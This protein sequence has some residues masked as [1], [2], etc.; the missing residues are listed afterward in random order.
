[1]VSA[2]GQAAREANR[3]PPVF[4]DD[5]AG[6]LARRHGLSADR[7]AVAG[8]SLVLLQ[9]AVLATASPGDEVLFGW[10][11]YEAYPIIVQTARCKG[12]AIPLREHRLDLGGLE[13]HISAATRI[14]IVCSPNNPTGADVTS[15]EL[16]SFLEVSRDRCLVILDEAYREFSTASDAP[17]GLE[18]QERFDHLLVLR[19]FSKAHN[20]AGARVGWGIGHPEIISALIRVALPFT[21]SRLASAAAAASVADVSAA[22][23]ARVAQITSERERVTT[24]L[25]QLGFKIPDSQANFFWVP[26]GEGS[27]E[28]SAA[29]ARRGVS[30]RCFSRRRGACHYRHSC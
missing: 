23:A 5:L 14:A 29:C 20:L 12:V 11:S 24:A 22:S 1:M 7:V 9:Q 4:G 21:L 30:V 17:N 19:T 10:R 28:F 3:Y 27:D 13:R 25:S 18:L 26:L 16:E 15:R 8:G 2:I 6:T